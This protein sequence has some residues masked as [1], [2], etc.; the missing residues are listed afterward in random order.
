[1]RLTGESPLGT[2]LRPA[3]CLH[4][5]PRWAEALISRF[6]HGLLLCFVPFTVLLALNKMAEGSNALDRS[7]TN[8]VSCVRRL[9]RGTTVYGTERGCNIARRRR[10]GH[11]ESGHVDAVQRRVLRV[12]RQ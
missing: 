8:S 10:P 2:V 3:T 6:T 12:D 7:G 5:S 11:P 9:I 1:M 4:G